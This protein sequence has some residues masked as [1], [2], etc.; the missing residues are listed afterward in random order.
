MTKLHIKQNNPNGQ[1]YFQINLY[2]FTRSLLS[3][4][5]VNC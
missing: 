1:W 3:I 2:E 4:R 5:A